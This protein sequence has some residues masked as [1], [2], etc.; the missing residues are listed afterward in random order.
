MCW[1]RPCGALLRA[2]Y[3]GSQAVDRACFSTPE[4]DRRDTSIAMTLR[5]LFVDFNS[6]FAS[7]EQQDDPR[8][9]G[10]PVGVVPVLA[11]TTC[12]IAASVE[13]KKLHGIGTGG[14]DVKSEV[15]G[16]MV[17]S[18]M[19]ALIEDD[20]IEV[21]L[22]VGKPP[23]KEIT[24][25]RSVILRISRIAELW[26]ARALSENKRLKSSEKACPE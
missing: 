2:V 16:I 20:E 25:G 19:E 6:F 12:C 5:C 17:L 18:A 24:S 23:A 7:V 13:A 26:M 1:S 14:R 22:V 11:A 3:G 9:R 8:L 10:K 4:N 21:L 15:G